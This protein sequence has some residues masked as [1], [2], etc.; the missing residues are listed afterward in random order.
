MSAVDRVAAVER[1]R[2]AMSAG[3]VPALLALFADDATIEDPV[4]SPPRRGHAAIGE[5]FAG[6]VAEGFT[7]ELQG[8]VRIAGNSAAFAF[9]ARMADGTEI[10]A[11]DIFE[12]GYD[13][14]IVAS[15]TY[16][17]PENIRPTP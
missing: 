7:L 3:D 15:R 8:P 11:I 17:G 16:W 14:R 12:F 6:A 10:D 1:Y 5:L 2:T 9:N 4:G 13:G